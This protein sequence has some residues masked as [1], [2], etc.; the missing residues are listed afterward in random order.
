MVNNEQ[1]PGLLFVRVPADQQ[2]LFRRGRTQF[3]AA[4][5]QFE[6]LGVQVEIER[7]DRGPR[8]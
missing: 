3:G 2:Q 8:R 6:P 4:L 5:S 7:G 1:R